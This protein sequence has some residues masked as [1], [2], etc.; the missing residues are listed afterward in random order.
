[1]I[2]EMTRAEQY[3]QEKVTEYVDVTAPSGR[4]YGFIKPSKFD[5]LFN[6]G[7]MPQTASNDAVEKWIAAG[8]LKAGDATNVNAAAQIESA[9]ALCDRVLAL[10][11]DPKLVPGKAVNPNELSIDDLGDA[12][13]E[14]LFKWV[15]SGGVE[16]G[17][18]GNFPRRSQPSSVTGNGRKKR[19]T[20]A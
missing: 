16:A 14:Y 20:K 10:S 17:R 12:D 7:K 2:K 1:M 8:V 15:A 13:A 4:V 11:H 6:Y 18:L 9:L 3:R 5:A 19:R